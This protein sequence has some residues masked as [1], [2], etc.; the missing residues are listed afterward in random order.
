M[1]KKTGLFLLCLFFAF[2]LFSME[3]EEFVDVILKNSKEY[4]KV[5]SQ[6]QIKKIE[7]FNLKYSW[8]PK[9]DLYGKYFLNSN[10]E[11]K[12]DAHAF[13]TGLNISQNIPMGMKLNFDF[14]NYFIYSKI[15]GVKNEYDANMKFSF[16]MPLY[17][18]SPALLKP[19]SRLDFFA[20]SKSLNT[21]SLELQKIKE[22]VIVQAI[23][24]VG[25]F[26]LKKEFLKLAE[27]RHLI[28]IEIARN[29]EALWAQG[30]LSS[31]E[32]AERD[33]KRY[34]NRLKFLEYKRQYL[35]IQQDL[36]IIGFDEKI[37]PSDIENWLKKIDGY[38]QTNPVNSELEFKIQ[39]NK[40]KINE[41]YSL[42]N[43]MNK[44]P[45]FVFS[46]K[47]DPN[48]N[49]PD[50][51]Q[52]AGMVQ[53]YWGEKKNWIFDIMLGISIPLSPLDD[54]YTIDRTTKEILKINDLNMRSLYEQHD[55]KKENRN[56][57]LSILKEQCN[58]SKENEE[59]ILNRL[60]L[61][62]ILLKQGKI[63]EIDLKIQELTYQ[64]A[65]LQSLESKLNHIIAMVSF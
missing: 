59:N 55:N 40:L 42:L 18:F 26:Y 3:Y 12:N 11:T 56:I 31:L 15:T 6:Y 21:A 25:S 39:E 23:Y 61:A 47:L 34:D 1:V 50:S 27:E 19:Y 36:K 58:L 62:K 63:T 52:F 46:V 35:K 57:R 37:V 30:K 5:L 13:S 64:T 2:P 51:T 32:L 8:I 49:K 65:K 33:T 28:D 44:M 17:F 20:K 53:N 14:D 38:I 45:R 41:Y 4:Q 48:P 7:A 16:L 43:Q 60:K 54:V 10:L 24:V 9:V 22:K 29:D